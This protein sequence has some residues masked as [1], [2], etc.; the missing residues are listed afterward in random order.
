M[1]A[2]VFR[3]FHGSIELDPTRMGRDAGRIAEEIVS[4]LTSLGDAKA[5]ITL[6]IDV[7]IPN[8][9]PQERVKIVNE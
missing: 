5:K 8:G 4:H 7:E 9:I 3:C 1:Q 2:T 6:E